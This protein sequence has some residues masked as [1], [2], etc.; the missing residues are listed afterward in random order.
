MRACGGDASAMGRVPV[1]VREASCGVEAL[2]APRRRRQGGEPV[3]R[4]AP[5]GG[6]RVAPQEPAGE[7]GVGLGKGQG[8]RAFSKDELACGRWE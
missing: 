7:E 8:A 1:P 6:Q 3:A 5:R 2:A 4:T